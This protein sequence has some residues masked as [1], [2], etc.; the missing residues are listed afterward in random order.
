MILVTEKETETKKEKT[1][2]RKAFGSWLARLPRAQRT[3]VVSVIIACLVFGVI[4]LSAVIAMEPWYKNEFQD[5]I[6]Q[7]TRWI[8]VPGEPFE[9]NT[10]VAEGQ[11][12]PIEFDFPEPYVAGFTFYL[13]WIDDARTEMDTFLFRILDGEGNQVIAGSGNTGQTMMPA[14]LNNTDINHVKNNEGW[15]VE[16]QCLEARDGYI[17]PAG[18]IKIPDDGNDVK[19]RFE[20]THFV[21]H[22]PEWE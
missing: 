7:K 8:E 14:R 19:V 5:P 13:I 11:T 6:D 20:W 9:F 1:S 3:V 17:G 18:V 10:Y 21:E 16:V 22:N 15:V 4:Y 2:K 12:V